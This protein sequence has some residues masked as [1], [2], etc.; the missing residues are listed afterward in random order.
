MKIVITGALGHIGSK[1]LRDLP[2]TFPGCRIVMIDS[3]MTQRYCS[4]FNLP[5]CGKY[6]FINGDITK[7]K[8]C[9]YFKNSTHVIH[10]AAMTDAVSSFG[11][12]KEIEANNYQGLKIIVK[13]VLQNR[14]KLIH[15]SSTSVY[16]IQSG[17]VNENTPSS[18]LKPQS[19]YALSKLKEEK[20]I[21][22]KFKKTKNRYMI[23]RFGTIAGVSPGMRF[24]TAVNKFCF[25]AYQN[26]PLTIWKTAYH[27]KRPYLHIKDATSAIIN[28][29]KSD[30]FINKTANIVS[31]N[32]SVSNIIDYI[33]KRINVKT[34]FT[35]N[36]IMNQ[37]SYEVESIFKH[38]FLKNKKNKIRHAVFDTIRLLTSIE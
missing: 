19:P 33:R 21:E 14:S 4:L 28:C 13:Y 31:E 24:H 16:G 29:I 32:L 8:L 37:H 2:K 36:K 22:K 1:L 18:Y 5:K 30:L 34:S 35:K 27:Q 17:V 9:P 25:Q 7:I 23:F 6:K 3:L 20:W 12:E 26:I 11:R 38:H 10:L 15:I